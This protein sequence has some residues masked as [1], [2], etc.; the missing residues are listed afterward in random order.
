MARLVRGF[1]LIVALIAC[2]HPTTDGPDNPGSSKFIYTGNR[3]K[4]WAQI[5]A[6]EDSAKALVKTEGCSSTDEC[7]TAPVGS[8]ACGGP[9]YYLVY[10]SRSTDSAALF[11]R[12]KAVA[13]GEKEFNTKYQIASTCEFRMPPA[14]ALV[15]SSCQAQ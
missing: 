12:L 4:D 13:D 5:V 7:R 1:A 11:A 10:C 3:D 14:V 9:R 8:R 15:G 2:A 6:L